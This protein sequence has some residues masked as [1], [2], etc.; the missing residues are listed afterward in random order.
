MN[1]KRR[2]KKRA[3]QLKLIF[4]TNF[5]A[6]S[7]ST[8]LVCAPRRDRFLGVDSQ[9]EIS[10]LASLE[11]RRY[12]TVSAWRQLV[13][14]SDLTHVDELWTFGNCLVT[15]EEILFERSTVWIL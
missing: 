3:D 9:Q 1:S 11:R 7:Y 15:F 4:R 2:N 5:T 6:V 10:L 8:K 14:P 12:D 13:S